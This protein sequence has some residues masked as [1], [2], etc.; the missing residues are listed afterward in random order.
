MKIGTISVRFVVSAL[1]A[2]FL[3]SVAM[4]QCGVERWAIKTAS[5]REAAS[6]TQRSLANIRTLVSI[7]SPFLDAESQSFHAAPRVRP[8]ETTIWSIT[9]KLVGF[10]VEADSDYK[11]AL[12]DAQGY[13]MAVE[14]PDPKCV[15]SRSPFFDDIASSRE[16]FKNRFGVNEADTAF[17]NI[18]TWVRVRGIGFFDKYHVQTSTPA[19]GVE[20]HPVISID[21]DVSPVSDGTPDHTGSPSGN[22]AGS[23]S[24]W[25]LFEQIKSLYASHRGDS[26]FWIAQ[27][28]GGLLLSYLIG[29]VALLIIATRRG[30]TVFDRNWL[31]SLAIRP[32]KVV[33]GLMRWVLFLGYRKRLSKIKEIGEGKKR[34]FGL[35]SE[36][37]FGPPIPPDVTGAKLHQ[38]I[39][40]AL[41]PQTPVVIIGNA[42]AGKSTLV[43]RLTYLALE[44]R[45][46][47]V[48]TKY[49]PIMV[50]AIYY[51]DSLIDAMVSTLRERDG[52]SVN[53]EILESQLRTGKFLILFD[54]IS[55]I[56]GDKK[57][58]LEKIL[59]VARNA[60]YSKCRFVITSRPLGETVAELPV[61]TLQPLKP[62]SIRTILK[63]FGLGT[64]M[65][66]H[67][68]R[69]LESFGD[70][71]IVPLLFTMILE[72]DN[73]GVDATNRSQ[74]YEN[75]FKKQLRVQNNEDEW[76]GW[77]AALETIAAF[78][79][80]DSGKRSV[81]RSHVALMDYLS[82]KKG[83]EISQESLAARLN[84]IFRLD[85]RDEFDLLHKS[86][87]AGI[88][89][90]SIGPR[91]RFVHDTFEEYFV[92]SYIVSYFYENERWPDLSRWIGDE[93]N[94]RDFC[95][96]LAFLLEMTEGSFDFRNQI[97]VQS[98]PVLWQ[99]VIFNNIDQI[100]NHN[101]IDAPHR[102][103]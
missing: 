86:E 13:S 39:T 95:E 5:D 80:I 48:L 17:R 45:L 6:I 21:F 38:S 8:F 61:F 55:Q 87:V 10:K 78:F 54:D 92:A 32:L 103:S 9:A 51:Q 3:A 67:L 65:I 100:K 26:W 47:S 79:Y 7:P 44:K 56:S 89:Q 35:P 70:H 53:R 76:N 18:D 91:W 75:Y 60:D 30:S 20:L 19:N 90:R 97:P 77:R 34:Y 15:D 99:Q 85:V 2:N 102:L 37:S 14:I 88:L 58:E 66:N 71:P 4:A 23:K 62:E 41:N 63:Q 36:I 98:L 46:S 25:G 82:G 59:R 11:L 16:L 33:P 96:V 69:F 1:L 22:S 50:P 83:P 74:I 68:N 24:S 52:V 40:S 27:A 94:E 43:A 29:L 101:H 84:R 42:G 49:I 12:V 73:I 31:L 28:V 57:S 93:D 64:P 72:Q 81:G